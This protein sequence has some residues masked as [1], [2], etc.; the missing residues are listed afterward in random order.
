MA[1]ETSKEPMK[2]PECGLTKAG[3]CVCAHKLLNEIEAMFGRVALV[4]GGVELA[5]QKMIE[6]MGSARNGP[7]R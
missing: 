1:E 7:P 4:P 2:C 6:A 3:G 5:E